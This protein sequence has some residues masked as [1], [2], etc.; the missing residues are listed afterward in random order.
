MM[1]CTKTLAT[2][3]ILIAASE[4]MYGMPHVAAEALLPQ[5]E[6]DLRKLQLEDM[7][8]LCMPL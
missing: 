1:K 5:P 2:A 7:T 3:S 4:F 6:E 8:V